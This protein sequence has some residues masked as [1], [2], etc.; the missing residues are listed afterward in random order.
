MNQIQE[1]GTRGIRAP[2]KC[3][4]CH[5]P[6]HIARNCYQNPNRRNNANRAAD[7]PTNQNE[8]KYDDDIEDTRSDNNDAVLADSDSEDER[9][10][11]DP[12]LEEDNRLNEP[13]IQNLND[14]FNDI[15]WFH[16]NV[17]RIVQHNLRNGVEIRE[18]FGPQTDRIYQGAYNIPIGTHRPS[19]FLD[20]FVFTEVILERFVQ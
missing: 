7:N 16:V 6:G 10:H 17:E 18:H 19:Q 14:P 8:E 2:R 20:L 4:F 3:S 13:Q 5:P 12:F 1:N 15:Y 9:L 11:L